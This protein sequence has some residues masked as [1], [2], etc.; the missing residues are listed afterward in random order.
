MSIFKKLVKGV[1][2]TALTPVEVLKDV[3]TIGGV[4]TD[5]KEPYTARRLKKALRAFKD[6]YEELD[7]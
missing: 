3:V 5:Q 6:A 7:E 4:S 1:L 2:D